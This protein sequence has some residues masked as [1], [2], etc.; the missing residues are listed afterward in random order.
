MSI[1]RKGELEIL[2]KNEIQNKSSRN[3]TNSSVVVKPFN[4]NVNLIWWYVN[5][6]WVKDLNIWFENKTNTFSIAKNNILTKEYINILEDFIL[7]FYYWTIK[8]KTLYDIFKMKL[9]RREIISINE[10]EFFDEN[11]KIKLENENK[12]WIKFDLIWR[13]SCKCWALNI[14]KKDDNWKTTKCNNCGKEYIEF[15]ELNLNNFFLDINESYYNWLFWDKF[16]DDFNDKKE[17]E[18]IANFKKT[19]E[20]EEYKFVIRYWNEEDKRWIIQN[21]DLKIVNIFISPLVYTTESNDIF[22]IQCK[23]NNSIF[24]YFNLE[25]F[26]ILKNNDKRNELFENMVAHLKNNKDNNIIQYNFTFNNTTE[27]DIFNWEIK[28]SQIKTKESLQLA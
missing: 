22:K 21:S 10:E 3:N 5:I 23:S 25:I 9:T 1:S 11:E 15:K 18:K 6:E 7:N 19:I 27:W 16:N 28:N 8:E 24:I 13:Y 12:Y 4:W 14:V 26:E 17:P 20:W 2:W